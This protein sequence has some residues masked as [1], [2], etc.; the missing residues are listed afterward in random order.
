M[1]GVMIG[2]TYPEKSTHAEKRHGK[3]L[4]SEGIAADPGSAIACFF[5]FI[6]I[7]PFFLQRGYS[8]SLIS[9]SSLR[10]PP[11]LFVAKC[12]S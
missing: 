10:G 5:T 6:K 11:P 1:I 7:E 3:S 8:N 9:H 4:I 12:I 2:N